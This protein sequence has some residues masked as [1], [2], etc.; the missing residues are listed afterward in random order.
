MGW[1]WD[2]GYGPA[3]EH[4]GYAGAVLDDGTLTGRHDD[5]TNGRFV[6]WR[7]AC[8]CGWRGERIWSRD[9]VLASDPVYAEQVQ[10]YPSAASIP[11]DSVEG[12][13]DGDGALAEWRGHLT[14]ALPGLAVHDA[15]T[16]VAAARQ[17]L[18][19]AVGV[20]RGA[21]ASWTVI[22]DAAGLTRQSAHER[23]GTAQPG[24]P[25]TT[26]RST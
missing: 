24:S 16:R 11:P 3:Y 19:H 8:D 1:T 17:E 2:T 9:D 20:A 25:R 15:A 22:G 21:G 13:D 12:D 7:A 23:W 4:E 6:G 5:L 14:S 26:I 18:D 10:R